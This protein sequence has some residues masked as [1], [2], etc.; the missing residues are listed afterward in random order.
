[1]KTIAILAL[2]SSAAAFAAGDINLNETTTGLLRGPDRKLRTNAQVQGIQDDADVNRKC[3]TTNDGYLQTLKAGEYTA[4][5]FHNCFRTSDQIFD[6][7][8]ALVAQ[9]PTLLTKEKISCTVRGKA[10]Y[11]YKLTSGAS[12]PRSL[13]FQSLLHAREWI[14]GSSNLFT[15]SSILDD[16]A[17]K[18]PTAADT[19]NLYFVPIVNIDGYDISWT[20][21]KRLQRKNA[22]GVD[23]NRNWP[24]PFKNAEAVPL[25]SELYPGK[26]PGSEPE[27]RGIGAWLHAKNS[28]LAGWVDVHSVK[29]LILY[30]YGDTTQPIGNGDDAK[31]ERLGRNVAAATG[32][33][34]TGQTA[35]SPPFG[36]AFGAFD[37]YL[38]RTYKKPVLTIEVAGNHFVA[39]VSTI[40]TRGT[41]IFK[42]LTQ[43][44]KE[45]L[46]F[47]G[48]GGEIVFSK[49]GN[50]GE[51]VVSKEGNGGGIAFPKD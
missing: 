35:A 5:K 31:F 15:L 12:K 4:S 43:F 29:G 44:A 25:W 51:I 2:A 24:T 7:V 28:E 33:G 37:D 8:D 34:Y 49:E 20:K 13:Y 45:V 16:I 38:Y 36:P 42:A 30:P 27:T 46:I 21:G 9:N 40:R 3:H 23:L 14:A 18:K 48:N 10:I 19:F 17:N 11:A 1:M 6:Y 50:G 22:K 39:H 26:N 32:G 41:E 47:E